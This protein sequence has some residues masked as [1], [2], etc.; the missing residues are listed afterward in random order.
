[1]VVRGIGTLYAGLLILTTLI[2]LTAYFVH[3]SRASLQALHFQRILQERATYI[4][5]H[6]NIT[7]D[8]VILPDFSDIIVIDEASIPHIAVNV[9]EAP[10]LWDVSKVNIYVVKHGEPV[11]LGKHVFKLLAVAQVKVGNSSSIS[12]NMGTITSTVLCSVSYQD[13][14]IYDYYRD[15]LVYRG[16]IPVWSTAQSGKIMFGVRGV[17]SLFNRHVLE[18]RLAEWGAI[19]WTEFLVMAGFDSTAIA[20]INT[21]F[22]NFFNI[23]LA[24]E[25]RVHWKWFYQPVHVVIRPPAQSPM[26]VV[27]GLA[28]YNT[29][30][31]YA[32]LVV[33]RSD[34]GY[35][36]NYTFVRVDAAPWWFTGL[37]RYFAAGNASLS[38]G[39]V[40]TV[41][42]WRVG[43]RTESRWFL[44]SPYDYER[45]WG[46]VKIESLEI[47]FYASTQGT[48][49]LYGDEESIWFKGLYQFYVTVNAA[50][51]VLWYEEA[52]LIMSTNNPYR[53][54]PLEIQ[55]FNETT[56]GFRDGG[57]VY[58][59]YF[60]YPYTSSSRIM[61]ILYIIDAILYTPC[62]QLNVL[63]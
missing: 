54:E 23:S 39:G 56:I 35:E 15:P 50:R 60:I 49:Q 28:H 61:S 26:L 16:Y 14:F 59:E 37:S 33:I 46:I 20:R 31:S 3:V 51:P 2:A 47:R 7:D 41:F 6:A 17:C 55:Q 42:S 62:N 11:Q 43:V 25:V 21:E 36:F 52:N 48:S 57:S 18:P 22:C 19:N 24:K 34:G 45:I 38:V 4:A 29:T 12:L 9:K 5:M 1:M 8:I 58:S 40:S 10:M 32:Y 53:V 30:H 27:L 63:P 44:P 13:P